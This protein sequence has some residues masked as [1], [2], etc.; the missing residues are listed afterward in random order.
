MAR[1]LLAVTLLCLLAG[2]ALFAL[3][4][5]RARVWLRETERAD[6]TIEP[7][8]CAMTV[9][10]G[11]YSTLNEAYAALVAWIEENGY[12]WNEPP[13]E[14]YRKGAWNNLNPKDWETEIY[15]PVYKKA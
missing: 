12:A 14:I 6:K 2:A 10:K 15:F 11:P 4:C 8:L 7:R 13:Y 9:Q 5:G 3:V 1:I